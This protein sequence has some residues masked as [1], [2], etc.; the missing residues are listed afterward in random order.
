[1][2]N[3]KIYDEKYLNSF[4]CEGFY[5]DQEGKLSPV[6]EIEVRLLGV[7]ENDRF[8]DIGCGRGEILGYLVNK[9]RWVY[10]VDYSEDAVRLTQKRLSVIFRKNII[11]ADARKIPLKS[12]TITKILMGD[13]IEH[14]TLQ[15][16]AEMIREAHRLLKPGGKLIIH[17]S[18]NKYF[19]KYLSKIICWNLRFFGYK[20]VARKFKSNLEANKV[21]HVFE[22]STE[23]L[24]KI[25][26]KGPFKKNFKIWI[27]PD[28]IRISSNNYLSPLKRNFVMIA[29]SALINKTFLLQFFG[30]DLFVSAVKE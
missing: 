2:L 12:N 3:S 13:I 30:N 11:K 26:Q 19:I 24:K 20:T 7:S 16:A 8:L 4:R 25:M 6:K 14:M 10:G 28:V 22:Y 5:E 29:L 1:M 17:T 23:D 15:E 27:N 18:P 21:Y 9:C